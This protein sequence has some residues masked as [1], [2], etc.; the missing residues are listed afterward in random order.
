MK[1]QNGFTLI[2]LVV[3][4]II[5]GILAVTAAP[6]FINLQGDARVS[7]LQGMKA[8]IQ[9]S[10][11]LVYSKSAIAGVESQDDTT[12]NI[13]TG[14][15]ANVSYGYLQATEADLENALDVVFAATGA[16]WIV[17]ATTARVAGVPA[18]PTDATPGTI[19][20]RQDGAPTTCILIYSEAVNGTSSPTFSDTPD[21]DDC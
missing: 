7:T 15:A 16:D 13:G 1:K 20:I 12:V 17:D 9:G 8:A 21:A 18:T 14:T 4:I 5:L 2:E 3:V 19:T 6:K 10:N 11:S